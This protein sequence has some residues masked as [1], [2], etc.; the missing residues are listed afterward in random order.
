VRSLSFHSG[1]HDCSARLL[2]PEKLYGREREFGKLLAPSTP[3]RERRAAAG[4]PQRL[5]R[6]GNPQGERF[7]RSWSRHEGC[8]RPASSIN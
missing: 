8:S 4:A 6:I 2:I 5:L 3:C 1:E 7:T